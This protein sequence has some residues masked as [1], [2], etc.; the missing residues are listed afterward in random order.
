MRPRLFQVRFVFIRIY[1]G[2]LLV[3][4]KLLSFCLLLLVKVRNRLLQ[5]ILNASAIILSLSSTSAA[6]LSSKTSIISIKHSFLSS[7]SSISFLESEK[8]AIWCVHALD[9][10]MKMIAHLLLSQSATIKQLVLP[11][12]SGNFF[13][14]ILTLES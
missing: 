7:L 2:S 11:L 4:Y 13:N 1:S 5:I 12:K 8:S 3:V 14:S 9:L 6:S 10:A